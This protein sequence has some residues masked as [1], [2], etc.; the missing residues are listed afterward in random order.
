MGQAMLRFSFSN[1]SLRI[2]R[3]LFGFGLIV[4]SLIIVRVL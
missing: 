1:F 3:G 2:M 4:L